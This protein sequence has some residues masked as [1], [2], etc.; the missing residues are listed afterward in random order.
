[1]AFREIVESNDTA[2]RFLHSTIALQRSAFF[3]RSISD[4]AS[5]HPASN[6]Y[7]HSHSRCHT[8]SHVFPF[9]SSTSARSTAT[10]VRERA[11]DAQ[12]EVVEWSIPFRAASVT[13]PR[14]VAFLHASRDDCLCCCG[15]SNGMTQR[16]RA[17]AMMCVL[18]T[19]RSISAATQK[20]TSMRPSSSTTSF[21]VP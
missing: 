4:A 3:A 17:N 11:V 5:C 6:L 2:R 1:M 10:V 19:D 14:P 12:R 21:I 20:T 7:P 15:G 13:S 9:A 8:L 18:R 16:E